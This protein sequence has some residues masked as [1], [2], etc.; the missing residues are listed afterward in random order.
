MN[1]PII[2]S[3][4]G[5]W[6]S[7]FYELCSS[8]SVE[9]DLKRTGSKIVGVSD[10]PNVITD[11]PEAEVTCEGSRAWILQAASM[12]LVFFEFQEGGRVASHSHNYAQWGMVVDGAMELTVDGKPQIYKKGDEYLIPAGSVHSVKFQCKARLMDLFCEKERY[13]PKKA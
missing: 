3:C 13:R 5:F 12:Q 4:P 9:F 1:E 10:F 7:F 6:P 2:T 8:Y 11:L